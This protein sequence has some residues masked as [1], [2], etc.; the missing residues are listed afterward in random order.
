MVKGWGISGEI[1]RKSGF[2]ES[3]SGL[4]GMREE[5]DQEQK[6]RL[7]GEGEFSAGV[8]ESWDSTIDNHHDLLIDFLLAYT[9]EQW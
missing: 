9:L 3:G 5:D 4:Q 8:W 2:G 6:Q 1:E 7:L